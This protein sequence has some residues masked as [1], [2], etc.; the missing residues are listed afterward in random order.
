MKDMDPHDGIL[1]GEWKA[2]SGSSDAPSI[3][4]FIPASKTALVHLTRFQKALDTMEGFRVLCFA[5]YNCPETTPDDNQRQPNTP[6]SRLKAKVKD[7]LHGDD[8]ETQLH[9]YL[10]LVHIRKGR[11]RQAA[12]DTWV[13]DWLD[14]VG[15]IDPA[16]IFGDTGSVSSLNQYSQVADDD[17]VVFGRLTDADRLKLTFWSFH[18]DLIKT[19]HIQGSD[20]ATSS[21]TVPDSQPYHILPLHDQEFNKVSIWTDSEIP[22]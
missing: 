11:L 6:M 21:D 8:E 3:V 10:C 2:L 20:L 22:Y 14:G 19:G 15:T 7:K 12:L 16:I 17:D 18:D 13:Q 9:G 5:W 4:L 1:E